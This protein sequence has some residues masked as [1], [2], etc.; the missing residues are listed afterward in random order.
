[1]TNVLIVGGQGF[2]GQEIVYKMMEAGLVVKSLSRKSTSN[3]DFEQFIGDFGNQESNRKILSTWV[4]EIVIQTAWVT[5]QDTY[6][7][8]ALNE[9]YAKSTLQFAEQCFRAGTSHFLSLGSSAEY[10]LTEVPSI[11]ESSPA[12]PEDLYSKAKL[13]TSK[14]LITLGQKYS[15]KVS[16]VRVFQPYG[17]GQDRSRLLPSYVAAARGGVRFHVSKPND[18]LDWISS[19]DVASAVLFTI[20]NNLPNIV[21]IGTGVGTSVIDTLRK[22]ATVIG[23]DPSLIVSSDIEMGE[24]RLKLLVDSRSAIFEAGWSPCDTLTKG[25]EWTFGK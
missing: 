4:P 12:K 14:G 22:T 1:M 3:Q 2:L 5:K 21:D 16:W 7:N 6:R 10:G 20:E 15:R 13:W 8:S 9:V 19:R 17:P 11:A 24:N 23:S 18:I 25:L